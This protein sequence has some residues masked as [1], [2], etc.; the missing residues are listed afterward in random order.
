VLVGPGPVVGFAATSGNTDAGQDG[1]NHLVAQDDQ[2]GDRADGLRW[3]VVTPSAVEFDQQVLAA[4]FLGG[5]RPPGGGCRRVRSSPEPWRPV[6][7][8]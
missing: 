6:E 7:Q 2:C 8:R 3:G 5:R 1:R 4:Q